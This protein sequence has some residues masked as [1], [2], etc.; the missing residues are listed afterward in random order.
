MRKLILMSALATVMATP[1]FA[2]QCTPDSGARAGALLADHTVSVTDVTV[3]GYNNA[4][5]YA[6]L[7]INTIRA[8][9]L[10]AQSIRARFNNNE[11]PVA[12]ALTPMT[13][14][15]RAENDGSYSVL[16]GCDQDAIRRALGGAQ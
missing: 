7:Q 6:A 10:T 15:V 1:A 12:M 16:S 9:W 8:G 3:R 5:G 2:C 14:A 13:L 11:C 4:N